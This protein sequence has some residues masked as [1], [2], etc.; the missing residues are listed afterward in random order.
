MVKA[1]AERIT[2]LSQRITEYGP[3]FISSSKDSF[4]NVYRHHGA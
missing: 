2:G 1:H 3:E 4:L